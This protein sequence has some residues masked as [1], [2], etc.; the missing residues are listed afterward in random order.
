[1]LSNLSTFFSSSQYRNVAIYDWK[2]KALI[3]IL[4]DSSIER[5]C[6]DEEHNVLYGVIKD[7]NGNQFIGR[8]RMQK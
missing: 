1:M 3:R 4:T 7:E 6:A 8:L 2:G 5:L